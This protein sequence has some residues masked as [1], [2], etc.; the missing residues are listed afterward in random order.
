VILTKQVWRVKAKAN[1]LAPMTFDDNMD[2]L[3]DDEV[4]L[5]KDGC[6]P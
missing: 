5:I 4:L 2:L 3:G 6:P 1:T